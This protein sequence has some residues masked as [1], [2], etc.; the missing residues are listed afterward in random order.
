MFDLDHPELLTKKQIISSEIIDEI[1]LEEDY[2]KR[3]VLI[4]NI[5][6]RARHLKCVTAF[7]GLIK[8][9]E[10]ML[11]EQRKEMKANAKAKAS[12]QVINEGPSNIFVIDFEKEE[13][14]VNTGK[15]IVNADGVKYF[16]GSIPIIASRYPIVITQRFTDQ[17]SGKE[18]LELVWMKNS[19]RNHLITERAN[20]ASNS[21]IVALSNYGF[22]ADSETAKQLVSYLADF[23]KLNNDFI[24]E[25]TSISK[26]G[27]INNNFMPYSDKD[28][29]FDDSIGYKTLTN[30]VKECGKYESWLKLVK[31]IRKTD[32]IE[33]LIY[34]A[35]SFGSVLLPLLNV[36]PFMVNLYGTSGK[37]KTVN[38]MLAASIWANPKKFIAE[39]T[40]TL[41][42]LEQQL[43]VVNHLPL[44]IDDLSKIRDKGDCDKLSDMIYNLCSGQ[45]KGRLSKDI[46]QRDPATWD[47]IILTNMERP[48]ASDSMQ[49]GAINR[50]L[51]F[52][53]KDGYIF[54]KGNDV[55]KVITKNYGH[56]G[57]R[58]VEV[59]QRE[60]DSII[61]LIEKYEHAIENYTKMK[62][63]KKEQKQVTPLA[64]LLATDELL[65]KHIFMDGIRINIEIADQLQNV[66]NVSEMEKAFQHIKDDVIMNRMNY[67]PDGAD[68]N[69]RGKICGCYLESGQIAIVKNAMERMASE[70]NFSLKQ[71]LSWAD[72]KKILDHEKNRK[73]KRITIPNFDKRQWCYVLTLDDEADIYPARPPINE[74]IPLKDGDFD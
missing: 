28:V 53:I 10:T 67:V 48:L 39:S 32:R 31:E 11:E 26:F 5:E 52:G 23:E 16:A 20:I 64:I 50:V 25:R 7:K 36:S 3:G 33:P 13:P 1:Y 18:K 35:A 47:N 49:G 71:F 38:L 59:V 42:S 34:M 19:R 2:V 58:F 6:D 43:N 62:G 73:D 41:N 9:Q 27:W 51:D 22:P 54:Q 56:A 30:S 60:K 65:E 12:E 40:S 68:G 24:K 37:G 14:I 63:T 45:G 17:E 57:K 44:M 74:D 61:G 8:A 29:V 46:K 15:W 72:D 69:Y 55:V 66:E 4:S 21:K 70:Y